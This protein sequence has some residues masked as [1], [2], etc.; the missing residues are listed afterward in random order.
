[1]HDLSHPRIFVAGIATEV[2]TFSPI[3]IGL[4]DFRASLLARPGEHPET[5][6]LCT[7]PLTEARR[8]AAAGELE[9]IE[10]TTAWADPG[11][12]INR[13]TYEL[14]RDEILG[15]L[16]AAMPIEGV[17]L[18]LHGAMVAQG[19]DD[20][21]GDLI[22]AVRQIVGPSVPVA[23]GLDPHSHL[24]AK[25]VA[26]ANILVAF[27]EF[28]HTDFV[29]R[30]REVI[31]L[32]LR[33]VR[34]EI[35][36][37][38][39]VFD[40][41]MIDIFPTSR[42]PMRS[43]VDKL[44]ALERE[45][46]KVLSASLIHGF[47]AGDVPEM[48]TQMLVV[49]DGD[50]AHGGRLAEQLGREVFAMRGKAFPPMLT[51]E[52]AIAAARGHKPAVI[53]DVWDNPGGGVA[54]DA[55]LILRALLDANTKNCALATIWDPIAVKLCAVAGEGARVPLRF[56]AK[57]A[58]HCGEPVDATVL[59]KK[60]VPD[61]QQTF[62][63]SKV[64]F[65]DAA[66]IEIEGIEVILNSIRSQAF[67]RTVFSAMGIDPTQKELLVVKSTNHF[68]ADFSKFAAK[69]IYCQAGKPYPNDPRTTPYVKAPRNIWPVVEDPFT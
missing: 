51:P 40:C 11:G 31:D 63:A 5:P 19:Y 65:G 16:R 56:G 15:Q 22:A 54:G 68:Y 50:R 37:V 46:A 55:T 45:D 8:R 29:E 28:P 60:I 27:K 4:E 18:C 52:E 24:T 69:V 49:T 13:P 25:R 42:E 57:S 34:G 3:F 44:F 38:M 33:T 2:N 62:G 30:G 64:P 36:P 9:L 48:G 17:A 21:E 35:A 32:L 47:M 41:R 20:P 26:G 43:F 10:G 61:A 39:S 7:A 66:L 12:L 14:L 23:A 6:T 58:P 59:V 67:E 1:L 53:A